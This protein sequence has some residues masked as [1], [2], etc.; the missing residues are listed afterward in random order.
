[1]QNNSKLEKEY[2]L[3]KI[4][5]ELVIYQLSLF[6]KSNTKEEVEQ[7]INILRIK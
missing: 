1:M 4:N 7:I 2:W 3:I 5:E 6:N